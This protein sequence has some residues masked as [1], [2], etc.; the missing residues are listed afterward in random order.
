MSIRFDSIQA[1]RCDDSFDLL[2]TLLVFACYIILPVGWYGVV[3]SLEAAKEHFLND[4]Q[5]RKFVDNHLVD[6]VRIMMDPTKIGLHELNYVY[7]SMKLAAELIAMDLQVHC[8]DIS[9]HIA[10]SP[11]GYLF[12][13]EKVYTCYTRVHTYD[14]PIIQAE[15]LGG[16]SK[17][18][19]FTNLAI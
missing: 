7:D 3:R 16:F 6:I 18:N 8:F 1:L 10:I 5:A 17:S 19:V 9:S 13:Q 11:L 4:D 15:I 2:T 12:N 14:G